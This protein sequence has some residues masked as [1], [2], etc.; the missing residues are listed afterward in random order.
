[1]LAAEPW[2]QIVPQ[3]ESEREALQLLRKIYPPHKEKLGVHVIEV[4]K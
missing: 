1:M 3:A 4:Q 2:Q